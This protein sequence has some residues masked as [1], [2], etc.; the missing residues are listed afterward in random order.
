M[1]Q[2]RANYSEGMAGEV[3]NRIEEIAKTGALRKLSDSNFRIFFADKMMQKYPDMS[4]IMK[5]LIEVS[6]H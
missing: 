6:N 4:D 5:R 1:Q 3:R 2:L